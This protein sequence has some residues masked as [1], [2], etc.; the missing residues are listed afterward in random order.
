MATAPP[1]T[2]KPR[3]PEKMG[4]SAIRLDTNEPDEEA[5][6]A[7]TIEELAFMAVLG[8]EGPAS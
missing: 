7:S 1:N 5:D 8:V 2:I 6:V 4:L 3:P